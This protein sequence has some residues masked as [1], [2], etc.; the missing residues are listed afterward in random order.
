[1]SGFQRSPCTLVRYPH[2]RAVS[3][4]HSCT[5]QVLDCSPGRC[6][7]DP[8]P[9]SD[10]HQLKAFAGSERAVGDA[11]REHRADVAFLDLDADLVR[12]DRREWHGGQP[13]TV[14]RQTRG[15]RVPNAEP[16]PVVL[17][18]RCLTALPVADIQC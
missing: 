16:T 14:R 10:V 15:A 1:M 12:I 4:D 18:D 3:L 9:P 7:A 13:L 17:L 11:A 6:S 8:Q 2:R 5:G